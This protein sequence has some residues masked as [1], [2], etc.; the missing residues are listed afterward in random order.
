MIDQK[1]LERPNTDI[2]ALN[3]SKNTS[4]DKKKF[5]YKFNWKALEPEETK[6][7]AFEVQPKIATV[8]SRSV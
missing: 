1:D 3:L 5:P 6:G 2:F 7:S 4:F 8:A